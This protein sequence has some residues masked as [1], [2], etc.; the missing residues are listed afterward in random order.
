MVDRMSQTFKIS[1]WTWKLSGARIGSLKRIDLRLEVI[2]VLLMA[3]FLL[4]LGL[5][6]KLLYPL[7]ELAPCV[8]RVLLG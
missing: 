8:H 6:K 1:L 3:L 5:T 7:P 2:I 4:E